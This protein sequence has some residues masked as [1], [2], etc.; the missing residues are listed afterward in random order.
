[1]HTSKY[2]KELYEP[3]R[4]NLSLM[5]FEPKVETYNKP[6]RPIAVLVEGSFTAHFKNRPSPGFLKILED[7]LGM[8][9]MEESFPTKM[10]F[11]SDG[12]M[13]K[14]DVSSAGVA[15]PLGYDRYSNKVFANKEFII[16]CVEYLTDNSG[17]IE[18]RSKEVRL[19]LL[20]GMKIKK[21]K[22]KSQDFWLKPDNKKH[23]NPPQQN[24]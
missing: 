23:Q 8:T 4:V 2:I 20:S 9:F 24:N 22:N 19:R 13:I 16:N 11:I 7:S 1:M 14:N 15:Q 12:D 18:T 5:K 10:I 17:I 6:E 21:S 3:V